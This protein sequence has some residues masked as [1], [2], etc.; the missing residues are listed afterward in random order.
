MVQS[1]YGQ[2]PCLAVVDLFA[3]RVVGWS[4]GDRLHRN[5]RLGGA[6][7]IHRHAPPSSGID[8]PLGPSSQYCSMDY[9][10][11]LKADGILIPMSGRGNCFDCEYVSAAWEVW[12]LL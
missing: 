9:Q 12:P 10:A 8:P 3:R 4:T 7:E 11:E 5:L 1:D 2:P 6:T